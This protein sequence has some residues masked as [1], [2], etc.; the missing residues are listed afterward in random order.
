MEFCKLP[1][2]FMNKLFKYL[3]YEAVGSLR[4]T[5]HFLRNLVACQSN[6]F[7][8]TK[9]MFDFNYYSHR[10]L[11]QFINLVR[12]QPIT[13]LEF[14]NFRYT[15]D[16]QISKLKRLINRKVVKLIINDFVA[17]HWHLKLVLHQMKV[18]ELVFKNCRESFLITN[19]KPWAI[20]KRYS[21]PVRQFKFF[22]AHVFHLDVSILVFRDCSKF[23]IDCFL[24]S[25]VLLPSTNKIICERDSIIHP[26]YGEIVMFAH[27]SSL[28]EMVKRKDDFK[29]SSLKMK[30]VNEDILSRINSI[31]F[32]CSTTELIDLSPLN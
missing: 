6:F 25:K 21:L 1:V 2:V 12:K 5:C 27:C 32:K 4:K 16:F 20:S 9:A 31:E 29:C 17:C 8:E 26:W 3:D 22:E 7:K 13:T 23:F 10:S 15:D 14:K 24:M 19:N 11:K 18:R 30:R 28:N